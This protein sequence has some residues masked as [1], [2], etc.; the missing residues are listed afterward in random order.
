MTTTLTNPIACWQEKY[1]TGNLQVD[2]QHQQI[3]EIVNA[4]HEAVVARESIYRLQEL[5]EYLAT[6]TIEH[7]QSEEALMMA[8][9]YPDYDRHK[10]NHDRL[11]SVVDSLLLQMRD[12]HTV[13]ITTDITQFLTDWLSHHIKGEDRKMIHFLQKSAV[14]PIH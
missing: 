6:H 10:Q 1:L 13:T 7:F 14:I 2:R 5:L 9:D 3:F 4:L 12:C 8:M 11:L